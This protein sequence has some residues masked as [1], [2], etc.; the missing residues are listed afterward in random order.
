MAA[1][2][3]PLKDVNVALK[4]TRLQPLT[5]HL[6]LQSI[7]WRN[8]DADCIQQTH[9]EGANLLTAYR[10]LQASLWDLK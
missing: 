8:V 6:I 1:L 9:T 10:S 7:K 4:G 5:S 3:L 2:L